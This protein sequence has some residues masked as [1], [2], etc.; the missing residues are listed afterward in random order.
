MIPREG[1]KKKRAGIL[2][3]TYWSIGS[4]Q[5]LRWRVFCLVYLHTFLTPITQKH[6]LLFRLSSPCVAFCF[7]RISVLS[8]FFRRLLGVLFSF[9]LNVP[10]FPLS[11][12]LFFLL[13][14]L[15]PFTVY[16]FSHYHFFHIWG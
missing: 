10:K 1:R 3:T 7:I 16:T 2:L 12:F 4:L 11:P 14:N 8:I 15:L 13:S 9:Y 6:R 5:I